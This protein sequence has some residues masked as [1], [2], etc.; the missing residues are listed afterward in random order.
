MKEKELPKWEKVKHPSP[1]WSGEISVDTAH[2]KFRYENY[3][4][5]ADKLFKTLDKTE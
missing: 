3:C 1:C 4:I 2:R 5:D